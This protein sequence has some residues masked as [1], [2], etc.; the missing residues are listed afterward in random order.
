MG[1]RRFLFL[2]P[3]KVATQHIYLIEGFLRAILSSHAL[4]EK[5]E[6]RLYASRS[7]FANLPK[8]LASAV[9]YTPI[10]VVNPEK[11]LLVRK[12]LME[13]FQVLRA[14]LRLRRGD[15]LFIS[16]LIPTAL[17]LLEFV[18]RVLGL[19]GI[20]VVMHDE[21][22]GIFREG[23]T[24]RT[25]GYWGKRWLSSRSVSSRIR[26][27]VLD[28][29]IKER[30]E[31]KFPEKLGKAG[32]AVIHYP[33]V[34][35]STSQ[36]VGGRA[37]ASACFVGYRT[38]SKSF[39]TFRLLAL[40]HPDIDF[41]AIG[42]GR[43]ENVTSGAITPLADKNSYLREI[44]KCTVAV[45]PYIAGYTC[46]LS[47]SALDALAAGVQI[48]AF[49]RPFF[50]GLAAYF[51]ANIVTVSDS[52]EALDRELSQLNAAAVENGWMK[53]IRRIGNSKYSVSAIRESF[54]HLLA[55]EAAEGG[56]GS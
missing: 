48:H 11:R 42:G 53:R 29:F 23:E 18:N 31:L 2:E 17:W 14:V 45:Y 20:C 15:V 13:F 30:L 46:S 3:S 4:T 33:I 25:I 12:S 55:L 5:W 44:S 10:A 8:D 26:P 19:R 7:T 24:F 37:R 49:D 9:R 16:C 32:I 47:A 34:P 36:E 41:L 43:V 35:L 40:R 50:C 51:G 56:S 54:E 21:L 38:K 1:R 52:E 28:D 39:D 27:I 6:L 22:E